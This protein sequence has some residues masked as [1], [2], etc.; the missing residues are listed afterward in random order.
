MNILSAI[1]FGVIAKLQLSIS[2]IKYIHYNS[3]NRN[4]YSCSYSTCR[5]FKIL[6]SDS[7]ITSTILTRQTKTLDHILSRLG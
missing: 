7:T 4:S 1:I 2:S 6:V 3:L 5:V